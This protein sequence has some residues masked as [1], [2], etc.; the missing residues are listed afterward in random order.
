MSQLSFKIK[1][2]LSSAVWTLLLL[3]NC[4]VINWAQ[5]NQ[6]AVQRDWEHSQLVVRGFSSILTIMVNMETG[7]RGYLLS[8]EESYLQPFAQSEEKFDQEVRATKALIAE[9]KDL[10]TTLS[11]IEQNKVK[12]METAS[13]EMIAKKKAMRGMITA[14]AFLEVFKSSKGKMFSD[15]IRNDVE[16]ALSIENNKAKQFKVSQDQ[17]A[18]YV[19]LSLFAGMPL[20]ILLGFG[21]M[22][23][24]ISILNRRL[25]AVLS[26]LINLSESIFSVSGNVAK[27]SGQLSESVSK[28]SHSIESTSVAMTQVSSIVKKNAERATEANELST[29]SALSAE[30]SEHDLKNVFD[31]ITE[32]K[33]SSKKIEDIVSIIEDIAFQTNLLALNAAVEAARAGEQGRGFAVVAEAVRNLSHRSSTAAKEIAT[34]AKDNADKTNRGVDLLDKSKADI[35][36]VLRDLKS[37]AAINQDVSA[38]GVEQSVGVQ[39]ITQAI[40]ELDMITSENNQ[41]AQESTVAAEKIDSQAQTLKGCVSELLI[42]VN[43]KS[44]I[45][46]KTA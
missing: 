28:Q 4:F 21:L 26:Q 45:S 46:Q 44:T 41:L 37:I 35:V 16:Q 24:L 39:E 33:S 9:D 10:N 27:A 25:Q 30:K 36:G 18:K 17:A 5:N 8:G 7:I 19:R 15:N 1:I 42:A 43:G 22:Y 3:V 23:F 2:I 40:N 14:E 12:W 31:A 34:L 11:S 38:S 20:S 6:S 29:R 32:V 13:S